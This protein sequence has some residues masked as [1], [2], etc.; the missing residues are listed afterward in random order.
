MVDRP[1]DGTRRDAQ[2]GASM[3]DGSQPV[4]DEGGEAPCMA[5]L[6]ADDDATVSDDVLARLVRDMADAVLIADR[7][8]TIMFW[9]DAATR[10]FGWTAREAIG[11][12]LDLIIP[13]RLRERH[14]TGW[15]QVA[16]TG[17][18]R[19]GEQLLEVPALHREGKRLSIAFTVSLLKVDGKVSA[20]AAVIRDDTE[21]WQER[22]ALREE[23]A[24]AR[25][26][27]G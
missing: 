13:E 25:A 11:E 15:Q 3:S 9:N 14:W 17:V 23:L 8:G 18:T 22:R 4:V 26:A 10:V 19:Y 1:S 20:I 27:Q 5:H 6:F 7:N 12:R 24:Q 16:E 2:K 21:R